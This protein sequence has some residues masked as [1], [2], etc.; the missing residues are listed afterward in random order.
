[1]T[2]DA[3][4]TVLLPVYNGEKY[5]VE[6][7]NSILGQSFAQFELLIIDDGS[8]DKSAEIINSYSDQRIR[9]LQNTK[10]IGLINTLN[11][12]IDSARGKYIA[13]MDAD[14]ICH[15][16]R[17]FMQVKVL[18]EQPE[19]DLVASIINLIDAA[20]QIKGAWRADRECLNFKE[21]LQC[22]PFENCIA[23]PS[24]MIRADVL[25]RFRYSLCSKDAE[26]YELWLR[27]ASVGHKF[28]KINTPLL[29]YR[30]H[31]QSVSNTS[32]LRR[33]C[34]K[35]IKAKSY[36]LRNLFLFKKLPNTFDKRVAAQ[37]FRDIWSLARRF[38]I[39]Y[40]KGGIGLAAR[41]IGQVCGTF[42]GKKN[43]SELFFFFPAYHIGGSE[44][45]H[46]DIAKLFSDRDPSIIM[47]NRSKDDTFKADFDSCGK[48]FDISALTE[49]FYGLEF[50]IG[51]WAS[52][53]DRSEQPILLGANNGFYYYLLRYIKPHV[54]TCDL[55]HAF[56]AGFE[57]LS[58]PVVERL[59][60][61]IVISRQTVSD[62]Q[63]LYHS[64]HLNPAL[65]KRIRV[66]ENT[67][68][69]P[70]R[71]NKK[72]GGELLH[73]LYVGRGGKEKRVNLI[74]R[75]ASECAEKELTV[76][77][78]LVGDVAHC[79][80]EEQKRM[81]NC[82]GPLFDPAAV[83]AQ[84]VLADIL[85]IVSEREG[86]PVVVMEGMAHGVV[87]VCTDVGG[88]HLHVCDGENGFLMENL[89]NESAL[90]DGFVALLKQLCQERS[91]VRM[92]SSAAY[93]YAKRHFSRKHFAQAYRQELQADRFVD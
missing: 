79:L 21:L 33:Y 89:D 76:D 63:R 47:T 5:I 93:N 45:V 71:I 49:R 20:G 60:K 62:L 15:P 19:I 28:Y 52:V 82:V 1:M 77:F 55:L 17:L 80:T 3:I 92:M 75:I 7:I 73:V 57:H 26:D 6:S 88:I 36:F 53:I 40:A 32:N 43:R 34:L 70:E 22:L 68:D 91:Q 25:K 4:I 42:F 10:N 69:I 58:L 50:M 30:I 13:R 44:R 29:F 78:T 87:P 66:I 61:R 72:G 37:F 31:H 23:H 86:F 90:V 16:E 65:D 35:D 67:V 9:F 24:V 41:Y 11:R 83:A 18:E 27:M 2:D 14:D 85:L 38:V 81:C 46:L 8:Q 56:G 84:Y 12:G 59:N 64:K 54:F 51:Y 39:D 48:L 74:G